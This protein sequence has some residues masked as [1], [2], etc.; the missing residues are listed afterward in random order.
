MTVPGEKP[1]FDMTLTLWISSKEDKTRR[2]RLKLKNLVLTP[3]LSEAEDPQ[4]RAKG[5][6]NSEHRVV[7]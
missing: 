3:V 5:P 4:G 6:V 2:V 1:G 7:N